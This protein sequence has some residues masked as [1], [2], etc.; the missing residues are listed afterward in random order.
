MQKSQNIVE[1][2]ALNNIG[3]IAKSSPPL[4]YAKNL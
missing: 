2:D 1:S 3:G 4:S